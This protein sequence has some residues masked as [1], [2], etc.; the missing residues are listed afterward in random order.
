MNDDLTPLLPDKA[1]NDY[2]PDKSPKDDG[3]A[4]WTQLSDPGEC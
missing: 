2:T 3:G 1:G 4:D